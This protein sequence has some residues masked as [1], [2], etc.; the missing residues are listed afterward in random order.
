MI[1]ALEDD[2]DQDSCAFGCGLLLFVGTMVVQIV[3]I[4]LKVD[5]QASMLWPFAF[6]RLGCVGSTLSRSLALS[7]SLSPPP[8]HA[9]SAHLLL[10]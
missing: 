1:I 3:F 2:G 5:E 4:C 8:P 9:A 10:I 6:G 7:L